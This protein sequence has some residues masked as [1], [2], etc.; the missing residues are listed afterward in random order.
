MPHVIGTFTDSAIGGTIVLEPHPVGPS[1]SLGEA[2]D[3]LPLSSELHQEQA[4]EGQGGCA[5]SSSSEA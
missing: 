4:K 5:A 3:R 2:S 1:W